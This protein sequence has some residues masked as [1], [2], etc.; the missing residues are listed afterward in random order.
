MWDGHEADAAEV[1]EDGLVGDESSINSADP[2]SGSWYF[3]LHLLSS[4]PHGLGLKQIVETVRRHQRVTRAAQELGCS[5]AYIHVRLKG[6]GLGL[7][8]VQ[9]A[10]ALGELLEEAVKSGESDIK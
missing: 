8:Q 2:E 1:G 3:P 6:A 5:D 4:G 10:E 7:R 9:E